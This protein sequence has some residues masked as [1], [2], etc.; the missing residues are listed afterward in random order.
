[1]EREDKAGIGYADFFFYPDRNPAKDGI[2]LKLKID[3]TPEAAIRQIKDRRHAL[4]FQGRPGETSRY[5]GRN[6]AVGIAY[7]RKGKKRRCQVEVLKEK[8]TR[9]AEG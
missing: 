1:M 4:C 9:H 8:E 3:H 6:V 2:I 5:T 7:D